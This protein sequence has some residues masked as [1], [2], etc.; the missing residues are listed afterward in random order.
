M[1]V[2]KPHFNIFSETFQIDDF[3]TFILIFS[4]RFYER[5]LA[6]RHIAQ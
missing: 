2:L 1:V 6:V 3:Q 4:F 5:L